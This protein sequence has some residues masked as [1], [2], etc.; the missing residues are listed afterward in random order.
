M[1]QTGENCLGLVNSCIHYARQ[2]REIYQVLLCSVDFQAPQEF[3][4]PLSNTVLGKCSLSQ[5]KDM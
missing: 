3:K 4:N 2:T 5:I 1:P